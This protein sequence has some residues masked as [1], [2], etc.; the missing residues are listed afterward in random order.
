MSHWSADFETLGLRPDTKVLSLGLAKFN[1]RTGEILETKLWRF[2]SVGQEKRT[3]T[4]SVIEWWDK[5]SEEARKE[6]FGGNT[7]IQTMVSDIEE[8]FDDPKVML[9]GNGANFD[10]AILDNIFS[11]EAPWEFWNVRDMRTIVWAAGLL[12]FNKDSIERE[13]THHSAIDDAVHQAKVIHKA[14]ATILGCYNA[15]KELKLEIEELKQQKAK[16][17]MQ[18]FNTD[19]PM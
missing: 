17:E 11:Y 16:L 6:A 13:G 15:Y 5:Q 10:V 19:V 1:I 12:G 7:R 8:L 2:N 4:P 14:Y 18:I 9:W 3:K